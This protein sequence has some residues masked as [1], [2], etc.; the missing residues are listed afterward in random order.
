MQDTYNDRAVPP[1]VDHKGT[2]HLE[3]VLMDSREV[4]QDRIFS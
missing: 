4:K 3:D 1:E 2:G